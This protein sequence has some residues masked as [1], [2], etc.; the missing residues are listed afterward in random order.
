MKIR[1]IDAYDSAR[2]YN[3]GDIFNDDDNYSCDEKIPEEFSDL[4]F[5]VRTGSD[6]QVYKR[7]GGRRVCGWSLYCQD[8]FLIVNRES[9]KVLYTSKEYSR[10]ARQRDTC[11]FYAELRAVLEQGFEE[12]SKFQL[13]SEVEFMD[14]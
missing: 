6:I 7:D 12:E 1:F 5:D 11:P 9:N 8:V 4:R 14:I 3:V 2:K 10:A 13:S